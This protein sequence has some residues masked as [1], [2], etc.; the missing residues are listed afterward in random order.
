MQTF[1]VNKFNTAKLLQVLRQGLKYTKYNF[2][3]TIVKKPKSKKNT[4]YV[5]TNHDCHAQ[6]RI[7]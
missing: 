1:A 7:G 2:A 4:C 6:K 5:S 3:P